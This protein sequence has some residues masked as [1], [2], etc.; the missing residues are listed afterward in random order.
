MIR[1]AA[2]YEEREPQKCSGPGTQTYGRHSF[3]FCGGLP[4]VYYIVGE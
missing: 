4:S 2:G 1:L 3:N